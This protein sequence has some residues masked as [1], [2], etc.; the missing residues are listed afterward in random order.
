MYHMM[1]FSSMAPMAGSALGAKLGMRGAAIVK[2]GVGL[3]FVCKAQ[4]TYM[5]LR[6]GDGD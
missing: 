4:S 2:L 5:Y 6:H 1:L 3:H